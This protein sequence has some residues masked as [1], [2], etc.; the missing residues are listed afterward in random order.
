MRALKSE[1]LWTSG[2]LYWGLWSGICVRCKR[3]SW[4]MHRVVPLWRTYETNCNM[5]VDFRS[6]ACQHSRHS[7][8]SQW[9]HCGA[10][11]RGGYAKYYILYAVSLSNFELL[12]SRYQLNLAA[13]QVTVMRRDRAAAGCYVWHRPSGHPCTRS[14]GNYPRTENQKGESMKESHSMNESNWGN[15]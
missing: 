7:M 2:L 4:Q 13:V 11:G 12:V 5:S 1:K 3:Y 6:P 8:L 10:I 14:N 9:Q 15:I